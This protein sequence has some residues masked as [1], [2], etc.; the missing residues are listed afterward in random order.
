MALDKATLKN[1]IKS[2]RDAMKNIDDPVQANEYYAEQ[3]STIIDKF[4]KTAK[5]TVIA[6][7]GLISVVGSPTAQANP[8]PITIT[9]TPVT[10]GLS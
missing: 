8:A 10:G 1:D 6:P 4:V 2:L 9:G 5:V 3:L 7:S